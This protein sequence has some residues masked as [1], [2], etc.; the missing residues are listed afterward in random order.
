M[1]EL[2]AT[3]RPIPPQTPRTVSASVGD[4]CQRV[5]RIEQYLQSN[6]QYEKRLEAR[7]AA[8][9]KNQGA[10]V[11][12]LST[13]EAKVQ[14]MAASL[15]KVQADLTQYTTDVTAAL[16]T[17]NQSITDL[18]AQLA[19][20]PIPADVQAKIDAVDANLLA[21]DAVVKAA[22]VAAASAKKH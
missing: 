13:L 8:L 11:A 19:A 21:A 10:I 5:D 3:E 12:R 20:N 22:P 9:E 7:V 14:T 16:A 17:L 6:F 1:P 2:P 15:D 4:L 18:K